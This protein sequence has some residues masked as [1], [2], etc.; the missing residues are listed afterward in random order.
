MTVTDSSL[1]HRVRIV[2]IIPKR[3]SID[4]GEF[5]FKEGVLEK[6]PRYFQ[7]IDLMRKVD[8]DAYALFARVGASILP[9]EK[10][11][12][13]I[14]PSAAGAYYNVDTIPAFGCVHMSGNHAANKNVHPEFIW[15]TKLE[16]GPRHGVE[17]STGPVF[18]V[19]V[20]YHDEGKAA[21]PVSWHVEAPTFAAARVLKEY[22]IKKRSMHDR[23]AQRGRRRYSIPQRTWS[24]PAA[25][26]R[27]AA[28]K[29]GLSPT[30][31]ALSV[32][33]MATTGVMSRSTGFQVRVAK[34]GRNAVFNIDDSV[35]PDFFSDRDVMV[36]ENGRTRKIFH[37][38]PG[39]KRTDGKTVKGHT[40]GLR[41]FEWNGYS[42]HIGK[43]QLDFANPDNLVRPAVMADD[44]DVT[45]GGYMTMAEVGV[46]VQKHIR[47]HAESKRAIKTRKKH[48]I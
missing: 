26:C 37:F 48:R 21:T 5:S 8:E 46:A 28:A 45:G 31:F 4:T 44:V 19:T 24:Y 32:F 38:V 16:K 42:V 29:P 11:L 40:K 14:D 23:R 27:F 3:N 13:A 43:P 33:A 6:L 47:E 10:S 18:H 9:A 35:S 41:E 25:L 22:C 30:E 12:C 1:V 36:N 7:Y 15:W 17:A 34:A 39:Y 2:N 20:L